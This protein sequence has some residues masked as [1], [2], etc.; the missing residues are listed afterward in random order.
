[1][2][3]SNAFFKCLAQVLFGIT[4]VIHDDREHYRTLKYLYISPSNFFVYMMGRTVSKLLV[5]ASAV[6]ITLAFGVF[7]LG[8]PIDIFGVNW[9]LFMFIMF[10]GLA[11]V[12]AFGLALAGLS[13]LTAKHAMG[14]NEGV[15]GIFY[16][17]CGVIFPVSILPAWGIT[18]AK[19][20]PITYWLEL[21]RRTMGTG[22][23]VDTALAGISTS[24]SLIILI[25]STIVF[26]ALSIG[27]FKLGDYVARSKGL[28][29]MTT[30]Y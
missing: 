15:A 19:A 23:G 5:T 16:L 30:A 27:I 22:V 3:D 26:M 24:T 10:I 6:I 14:M 12:M 1:M 29:D 13:F 11:C 17:F 8:V 4:W 25:V 2:Y 21:L 28:I 20:L 18:L 9:L 7:F